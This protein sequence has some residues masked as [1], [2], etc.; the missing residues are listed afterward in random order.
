MSEPT[1]EESARPGIWQLALP[2]I[3]GNL[4]YSIVGMVQTKFVAELGAQGLAAVGA[5]QRIFF[6]MQA[7]LMAVSAGTTALVARAWGAGDYTEASRVTMASLVL[8]AALSLLIAV[9][10]IAFATPVAG[11]FG[12]DQA[13]LDMASANIRW[14]SAFNVVFAGTFILSAALRAS[15]DAWTPLWMSV[16]VNLLNVP[17]LYAFIFGRWGMPEMGVAGA[18]VAAGIAFS[19]GTGILLVMWIRQKFR[20]K[21]VRGGWWRRAR[22]RRLLDIGYPAA[23]EQGVFQVGFFIFLMLIGNFYGTEAFAAYNIGVNM[24]AICMT[25]GFGF[26]IAGSTLVGQHLGAED[27]DGATRSGWRALFFAVLSMGGLGLLII[28]YAN[29]LAEFFLGDAPLT[30][31][32]TVQFTYMLGAMM[33]L[34]AVDFAIGGALRGAGDTRF[35]LVATI[36]GLLVMRCGLAGIA[37]YLKM[38]VIYVYAAIIG[39][40]VLKGVM[41]V[42]RFHRGKWKTV[43]MIDSHNQ[44]RA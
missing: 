4:S 37:T 7:I 5:G 35:P 1:A 15:G 17:L 28:V 43:V 34:L 10:G 24:L 36:L 22:L 13:T 31:R 32:Y 29:E 2:S 12:L 30:I 16:G 3:L 40:Y 14:L 27:H 23:L 39:D 44:D 26:S 33:P 11:V 9:L 41:L 38:P 8:G 19:I 21:H 25:V 42:W 20:V 6:A 18:A